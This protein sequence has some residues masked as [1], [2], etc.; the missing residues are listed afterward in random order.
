MKVYYY[1]EA[2]GIFQGEEFVDDGMFGEASGVTTIAPPTYAR[3]FIS[4]FIPEDR[5]WDFR[6]TGA[7]G[8][9]T[10]YRQSICHMVKPSK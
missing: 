2:T 4:V 7:S 10:P 3:G 9:H 6:R 8:K 1:D 5:R